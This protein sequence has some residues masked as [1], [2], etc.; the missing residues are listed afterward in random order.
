MLFIRTGGL[1]PH[2]ESTALAQDILVNDGGGH[3]GK[4]LGHFDSVAAG[5]ADLLPFGANEGENVLQAG[6]EHTE[7]AVFDVGA[8]GKQFIADIRREA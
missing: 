5:G 7:A 2:L 6:N 4:I 3:L 1:F 8:Q